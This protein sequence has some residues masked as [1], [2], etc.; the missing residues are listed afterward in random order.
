ME[1]KGYQANAPAP[2]P[3]GQ[4]PSYEQASY[5]PPS[6]AYPPMG[7]A[8]PP[9]SQPYPPQSQGTGGGFAPVNSP[10]AI[11]QQVV[12]VTNTRWSPNPMT[13]TCPFCRANVTTSISSEPGA[14]AWI[15]GG[16]LCVFG[17][18]CCACIPCC[19]DSLKDVKHTCPNCKKFLGMYKGNL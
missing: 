5:P 9:P 3:Y 2:D 1:S 11:P 6:Q 15:V 13:I 18:W 12:V 14:M 8:Y 16:L 4:P 19:I 10:Q 17:F 7:Q